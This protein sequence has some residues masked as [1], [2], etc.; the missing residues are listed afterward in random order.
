MSVLK[1]MI[2][3]VSGEEESVNRSFFRAAYT[4]DLQM[5]SC[6]NATEN[7]IVS[8]LCLLAV[9]HNEDAVSSVG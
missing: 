6:L 4:N 3:T 5:L 1:Q 8:L 7:I 2:S 9:H